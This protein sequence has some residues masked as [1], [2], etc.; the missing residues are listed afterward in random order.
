MKIC[1]SCNAR[2]SESAEECRSCGHRWGEGG[3]KRTMMGLPALFVDDAQ[4]GVGSREFG[5][6]AKKTQFGLPAVSWDDQD[7]DDDDESKTEV[8]S[9]EE[10]SFMPGMIELGDEESDDST[11]ELGTA[12]LADVLG[13]QNP[14]ATAFGLPS[15]FMGAGG[16]DSEAEAAS[17]WGLA[18]DSSQP[19]DSTRVSSPDALGWSDEGGEKAGGMSVFRQPYAEG[20]RD[21]RTLMGMSLEEISEDFAAGAMVSTGGLGEADDSPTRVVG[22]A[23]FEQFEDGT[24]GF[25]SGIRQ[26]SDLSGA[27]SPEDEDLATVVVADMPEIDDFKLPS[28]GAEETA[29][30]VYGESARRLMP[31]GETEVAGIARPLSTFNKRETPKS[32]V[33]RVPKRRQGGGPGDSGALGG[34]GTYKVGHGESESQSETPFDI[35]LSGRESGSLS[36]GLIS[37]GQGRTSFPTGRGPLP[38]PGRAE[39][40]TVETAKGRPFPVP[41]RRP[42]MPAPGGDTPSGTGPRFAVGARKEQPSDQALQTSP[43][44]AFPTGSGRF[45]KVEIEPLVPESQPAGQSGPGP[46]FG[47]GPGQSGGF[48]AA[49]RSQPVQAQSSQP[50]QPAQPVQQQ[51]PQEPKATEPPRQIFAPEVDLSAAPASFNSPAPT[52]GAE[53]APFGAEPAR[54]GANLQSGT[55]PHQFGA[56]LQAPQP[57]AAQTQTPQAQKAGGQ[58]AEMVPLMQKMLAIIGALLL[59]GTTVV[60]LLMEGGPESIGVLG[61]ILAPALL[62]IAAVLVAAIPLSN[63]V[64]SAGFGAVTLLA[65]LSAAAAFVLVAGPIAGVGQIV[66]GLVLGGAA[67]LPKFMSG[68]AT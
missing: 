45:D 37:G 22:P 29:A 2:V 25:G 18:E 16:E 11:K 48:P 24:P 52:F 57:L 36:G 38:R 7:V 27:A 40:K 3:A 14:K 28:L 17:A 9:P 4:K 10:L 8:I 15:P 19:D 35:G 53:P 63:K 66:G 47:V 5:G 43:G 46:A 51:P 58:Q 65:F 55:G 39:A 31:S 49:Q 56:E 13:Q 67:A 42:E 59:M 12:N 50:V 60:A 30:E 32:G 54:P 64:R 20:E 1:P 61:A 41:D 33:F 68:K 26:V 21:H 6:E 44:P 34:T 62:A 23:V